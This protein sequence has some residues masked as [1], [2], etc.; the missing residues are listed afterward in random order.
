MV[1]PIYYIN[2]FYCKVLFKVVTI[3]FSNLIFSFR[4]KVLF[5]VQHEHLLYVFERAHHENLVSFL[6]LLTR[7]NNFCNMFTNM[8][9]LLYN[10]LEF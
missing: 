8:I 5:E 1:A 3:S 2:Q 6:Q 9:V 7:F 4:Q 10:L